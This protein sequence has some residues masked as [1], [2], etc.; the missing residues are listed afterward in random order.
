MFQKLIIKLLYDIELQ[1]KFCEELNLYRVRFKAYFSNADFR[2]H[3]GILGKTIM[4]VF[5]RC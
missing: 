2:V 4:N 1:Q 5:S 3:D